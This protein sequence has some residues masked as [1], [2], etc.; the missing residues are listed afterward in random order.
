[1]NTFR[2]KVVVITGGASGIGAA[3][4]DRFDEA[5]AIVWRLDR[6]IAPGARN[7]I[8][9][10]TDPVAIDDAV[11]TIA[12]AK[13]V[14]VLVNS[15]GVFVL[16]EW[17]SIDAAD[18]RRI[19][20]VN[21]LG[22]TLMTQAVAP[23]MPPGSSIIN[24]ASVAGRRGNATSVLY[25]ASKSAVISLTQSAALAFA[26]RAIRVNAVAP[27]RIQTPMLEDIM[28]RRAEI[29]GQSVAEARQIMAE[30]IPLD[31]VATPEDIADPVLFLAGDASRYMT[32]QTVNVD[33]GLNFN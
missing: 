11:A 26:T 27:G 19:F 32:G 23:H 29:A 5:G 14:D 2:D 21:V 1:M 31:R 3:I 28:R 20:D 10:V 8:V 15:A 12:A 4:A 17:G 22:L 13:P 7:L 25:A 6:A 9:D 30:G 33:G 24:I 16:Q 18:Y